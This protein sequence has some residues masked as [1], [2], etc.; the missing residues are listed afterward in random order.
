MGIQS[1]SATSFLALAK[2]MPAKSA[3]D[4]TGYSDKCIVNKIFESADGEQISS[5]SLKSEIQ[6][7]EIQQML[8]LILTK[9]N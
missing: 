3:E 5:I 1:T 7:S 2:P 6:V 9:S 8:I 4:T